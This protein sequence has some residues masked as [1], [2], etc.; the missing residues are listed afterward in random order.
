[1]KKNSD[2]END[3]I[4]MID[5][6][7]S[8]TKKKVFRKK[9]HHS[10]Q[11]VCPSDDPL[12]MTQVSCII[13]QRNVYRLKYLHAVSEARKHRQRISLMRKVFRRVKSKDEHRH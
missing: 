4:D 5:D 3:G 10:H 11:C 6:F 7:D 9:C 13:Y 1:M 2:N 8:K 12:L